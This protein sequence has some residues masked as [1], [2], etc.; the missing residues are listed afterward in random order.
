MVPDR[1][2]SERDDAA[3]TD[4]LVD[5][6][7]YEAEV[8]ADLS[9]ELEA[10]IAGQADGNADDE[11]DAEG[12]TIGFERARVIALLASAQ[13]RL[14]ALDLAI[15]CV[16]DG[17]YGVCETCGHPIPALRL[18]ALPSTRTCVDCAARRRQGS[19]NPD[20]HLARVSSTDNIRSVRRGIGSRGRAPQPR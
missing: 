15:A 17:T 4:S 16:G 10:I 19:A 2:R 8:V 13:S 12:S 14:H 18:E 1:R 9:A 6:M 5:A 7:A 20:G 11:H 3:L